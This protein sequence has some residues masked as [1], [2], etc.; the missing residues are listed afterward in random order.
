MNFTPVINRYIALSQTEKEIVYQVTLRKGVQHV[1]VPLVAKRL[2]ILGYLKGAY[3]GDI[4]DDALSDSIRIFQERSRISADG[5][6][7]PVTFKYLNAEIPRRLKELTLSKEKWDSI[8]LV[9]GKKII[10]NIPAFECWLYKDDAQVDTV[11]CIVGRVSRQTV[12]FSN[13]VTY[14][15]FRPYWYV[16]TSIFKN[17]KLPKILK[18]GPKYLT[19]NNFEV[20][21]GKGNLVDPYKL[22]W[23]KYK[24]SSFP[25]ILRQKP[26]SWNALGLV[27][28][29]FPNRHSI[30]MHD[31]PDKD[32]FKSNVRAFSSGCVRLSNPPK[33]GSFLLDTH[34]ANVKNYMH[35]TS[36]N[37]RVVNLPSPVPIHIVYMTAWIDN[38]GAEKFGP[39]I[40][41]KIN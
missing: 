38:N 4:V 10:V 7:G 23:E 13:T 26:G 11:D 14:A 19:D 40:Y 3:S 37:H 8:P 16:P 29:M 33:M 35:D 24:K 1:T 17:D 21:D 39:D 41:S 12:Q 34:E 31:T 6:A 22:N 27:K 9:S 2:T 18:Y 28:Y 5:I 36:R 30:Y 15:D 25:Y 32:L 20:V